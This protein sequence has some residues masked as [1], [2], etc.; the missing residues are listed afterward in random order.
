MKLIIKFIFLFYI[1]KIIII[2]SENYQLNGIYTTIFSTNIKLFFLII[3]IIIY[4]I[5]ALYILFILLYN[6]KI[7]II[8]IL[9]NA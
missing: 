1:E 6:I 3:W 5:I 7:E 8:V 2:N 9:F 4:K